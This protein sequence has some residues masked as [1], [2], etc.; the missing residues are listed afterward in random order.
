MMLIDD[1]TETIIEECGNIQK[2]VG[3]GLF[4]NVYKEI[5]YQRLLRK[6]LFVQRQSSQH[7]V[8]HEGKTEVMF[9]AEFIVENAVICEIRSVTQVEPVDKRQLSTYLRL[10]N[11]QKGL[12]I[13][14]NEPVEKGIT[15]IYNRQYKGLA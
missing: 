3:A 1:I 8:Y 10:A 9:R 4:D 5:L 12:L 15:M 11:K 14:F 13:N 7:A 2:A 6:G